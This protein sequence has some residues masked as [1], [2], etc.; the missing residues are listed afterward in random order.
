[1]LLLIVL[2][3]TLMCNPRAYADAP[4]AGV[5][6]MADPIISVRNLFFTYA[7]GA[8]A[9]RNVTLDICPQRVVCAVWAVALRQDDPA[10][11]CSTGC[12]I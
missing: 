5:V 1:M 7:D 6:T 11:L 12:P 3:L 4:P 9:L 8:E 10:A 2:S